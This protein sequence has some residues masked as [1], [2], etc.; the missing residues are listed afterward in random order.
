[1]ISE[2]SS[3]TAAMGSLASAS[4]ADGLSNDVLLVA[5]PAP[6]NEQWMA[7]LEALH[8]GLKVRWVNQPPNFPPEPLPRE[9]YD[10]VTMMVALCPHPIELVQNVRSIQL[11]SAGVDAWIT[12]NLYN[13]LALRLRS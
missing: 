8:P 11:V 4:S 6:A 9:L 3:Q 13:R 7:R 1:M 10:G 5:I 2:Q 12:H